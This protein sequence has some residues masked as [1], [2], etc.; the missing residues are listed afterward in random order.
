MDNHHK[1]H[2]ITTAALVG[3]LFSVWGSIGHL[4]SIQS[5]VD[6][7]HATYKIDQATLDA[8][9]FGR[10]RD[11]TIFISP[12]SGDFPYFLEDAIARAGD[13][14]KTDGDLLIHDGIWVSPDTAEGHAIAD[15]ISKA[16]GEPVKVGDADNGAFEIGVGHPMHK[17]A[18]K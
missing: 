16:I 4:T 15:A 7:A 13:S 3:G 8:I 18:A 12:T 1:V 5:R 17:G 9:P 2:Y 6:D 10:G 14:V 11:Y